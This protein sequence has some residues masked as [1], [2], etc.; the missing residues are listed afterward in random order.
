LSYQGWVLYAHP[1]L[2]G[3]IMSNLPENGPFKGAT[4]AATD[5]VVRQELITYRTRDGYLVR[6]TTV[7][8][9]DSVDYIDN[10][11]TAVLFKL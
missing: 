5:D 4:E 6:E 7:R 2:L 8:V 3:E 11:T 1:F 10:T 9:F